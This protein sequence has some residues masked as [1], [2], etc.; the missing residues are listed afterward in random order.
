MFHGRATLSVLDGA[1]GIGFCPTGFNAN[2]L[3]SASVAFQSTSD[4]LP[5]HSDMGEKKL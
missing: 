1:G 4:P 2:Q 3:L 5:P